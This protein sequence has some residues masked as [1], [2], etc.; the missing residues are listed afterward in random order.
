MLAGAKHVGRHADGVAAGLQGFDRRTRGD[1]AHH[2]HRDRTFAIFSARAT[3]P[4]LAEIAFDDAGR[5][6]AAA[7]GAAAGGKLGQ[8][9]HLDGAG[10]IGQAANEAAFLQSCDEAVDARL[11][12]EVERI[13]HLVEGGRYAGLFQ[14]FIDE[15]QKFVLFARE[16]LEQ[17]PGFNGA[18]D[19]E[20]S[21]FPTTKFF[22]TT[23]GSRTPIS[24]HQLISALETNHERTL[25]VRYVF[26]NHLIS[27]ERNQFCRS[28]PNQR[29]SRAAAGCRKASRRGLRAQTA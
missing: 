9:D 20:T 14:P 1:A 22:P 16:H 23:T 10:T 3:A 28:G 26:R 21:F 5:E 11:R 17:S 6:A 27:G 7:I 25:Y 19:S 24:R 18:V 4:N 15:T 13:L 2:G 29:L 12:A 8:L